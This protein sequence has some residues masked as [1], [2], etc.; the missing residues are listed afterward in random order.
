M[1]ATMTRAEYLQAIAAALAPAI[2]TRTD[3]GAGTVRFTTRDSHAAHF[4]AL[5]ADRAGLKNV[6]TITDD[7][8]AVI[9]ISGF[10]KD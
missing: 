9:T 10:K 2:V 1:H 7:N 4:Y 3:R 8:T 6:T 5:T